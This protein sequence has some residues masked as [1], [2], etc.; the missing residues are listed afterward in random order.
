MKAK[1][2]VSLI[3]IVSIMVSFSMQAEG[4]SV[5]L[6]GKITLA[7]ILAGFALVTHVLVNHDRHAAE[8]LQFQ[9]GP[10]ERIIQFER[11]FEK[12]SVNY[13]RDHYYMFL[14]NRYIR[15]EAYSASFLNPISPDY[16]E[17]ILPIYN[18]LN[19]QELSL[20]LIGMPFLVTPKWLSLYQL[21]QPPVLQIAPSYLLLLEVGHLQLLH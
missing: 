6:R 18:A 21:H 3:L 1:R 20:S 7:G 11:G 5:K 13:Y 8:T 9:L 17:E 4:I 12:W 16:S 14:N 15:K 2:L 10:P 19:R